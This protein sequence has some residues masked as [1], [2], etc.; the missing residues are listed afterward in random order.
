MKDPLTNQG[1]PY[2]IV[3]I[4][5]DQER[6]FR[7]GELPENYRLPAHERLMQRG[8]T[9]ENHRISSCVCTSSR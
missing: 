4:L 9:F 7:P 3:F 5:T 2:N 6:L 8:V 1:Q